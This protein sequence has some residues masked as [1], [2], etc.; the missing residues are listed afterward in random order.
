M[1]QTSAADKINS[2]TPNIFAHAKVEV[3]LD[4]FHPNHLKVKAQ[5]LFQV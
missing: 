1:E 5:K 4:F 3:S 2:A